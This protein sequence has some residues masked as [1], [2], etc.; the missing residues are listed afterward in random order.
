M[1]HHFVYCIFFAM[2][3]CLSLLS[4]SDQ[5]ACGFVLPDD[6]NRTHCIKCRITMKTKG[7]ILDDPGDFLHVPSSL[8]PDLERKDVSRQRDMPTYHMDI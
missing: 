3:R 4:Y 2:V 7:W 5:P 6:F 1:S 8:L